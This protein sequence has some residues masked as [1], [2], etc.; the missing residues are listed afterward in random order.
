MWQLD[1]FILSVSWR[2]RIHV[3]IQFFLN[4]KQEVKEYNGIEKELHH[5][6][7]ESN[8]SK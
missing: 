2:Q 1:N 5:L 7:P 6:D 8:G 4:E 3:K